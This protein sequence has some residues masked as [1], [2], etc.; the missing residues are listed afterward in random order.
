MDVEGPNIQ[1]GLWNLIAHAKLSFD[2]KE[3]RLKLLPH[4]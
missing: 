3:T 2:L 4:A 1:I